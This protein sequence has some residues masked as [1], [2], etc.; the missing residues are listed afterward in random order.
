MPL[1]D[2]PDLYS[3][4]GSCGIPIM[5][6]FQSWSEGIGVFGKESMLKLWSAANGSSTREKSPSRSSWAWCPI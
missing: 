3:H 1:A 5:S 4:Y 6:V 2:L